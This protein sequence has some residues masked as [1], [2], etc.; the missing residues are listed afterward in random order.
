[1]PGL[2]VVF[3]GDIP[4]GAGVSSSAAVEVAFLLAW[5]ALADLGLS[6]RRLAQLGQQVENRFLGVNSGIMD[7]FATLHGA[8]DRLIWL[9]CRTLDH[10][11]IPLPANVAVLVADS[12]VR[13]ELANSQYN[14]RREQCQEALTALQ[15]YVP[16]ARALRDITVE[17]LERHGHRLPDTLYRRAKHVVQECLRVN[18]GV[19]QLQQ[20]DLDAFGRLISASHQS[21][22]DLFEVSIP[23]LDA[24]A[25]TASGS[26]GCYGARLTGAGFGGCVVALVEVDA[27]ETVATEV[28][29]AYARRFGQRPTVFACRVADGASYRQRS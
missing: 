19:R 20:D 29:A 12:G 27:A 10:Q 21:S 1:M 5:N 13:R 23:E 26:P 6:R 3:A 17:H 14:L 4:I 8:A 15:A 9:D 28:Q 25:E 7:Q 22:R 16:K 2:E 24:L 11:L 18:E